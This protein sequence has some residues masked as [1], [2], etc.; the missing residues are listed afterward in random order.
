MYKGSFHYKYATYDWFG[1]KQNG[2]T[3]F[4]DDFGNYVKLDFQALSMYLAQDHDQRDNRK[5]I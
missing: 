5:V 2:F 3:Y 4:M 1:H